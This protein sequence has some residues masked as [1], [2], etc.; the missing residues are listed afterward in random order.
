MSEEVAR[1]FINTGTVE[2]YEE[3]GLDLRFVLPVLMTI[4]F[5]FI[6]PLVIGLWSV[7]WAL[8]DAGLVHYSGLEGQKERYD[9]LFEI[10]PTHM[11]YNNYLKGYAGISS[12]VFL[13]SLA[14][15]STGFQGRASDVLTVILIPAI[16][17]IYS[18]PPY[19]VYGLE[20]GKFRNL[21]KGLPEAK[22]I[23]EADFIIKKE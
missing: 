15:Y 7:G 8:A 6:F 23:A 5:T 19:L 11:K 21:R 20:K 9:K 18:I 2:F 17:I 13:V 12:V 3:E 16:S 10:E 22:R 1:M 4:T 14:I